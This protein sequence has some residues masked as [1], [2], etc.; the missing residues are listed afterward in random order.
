MPKDG[1]LQRYQLYEYRTIDGII[2]FGRL[3]LQVLFYTVVAIALY[4]FG[5]AGLYVWLYVELSTN[6]SMS[7]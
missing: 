7:P 1:T 2:D 6:G 4:V 3:R 5:F